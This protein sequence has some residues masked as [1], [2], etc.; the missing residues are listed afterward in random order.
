[1]ELRFVGTDGR[2]M[3]SV[4]SIGL[5]SPAQSYAMERDDLVGRA[6]SFVMRHLSEAKDFSEIADAA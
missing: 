1:M 4:F 2:E 3:V 5:P 6:A